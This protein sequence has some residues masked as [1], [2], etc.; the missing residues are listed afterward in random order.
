MTERE[1]NA[2]AGLK[3]EVEF[4]LKEMVKHSD[5]VHRAHKLEGALRELEEAEKE[6]DGD[7]DE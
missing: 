1:M 4:S 7:E 6:A 3:Q 2:L 5:L